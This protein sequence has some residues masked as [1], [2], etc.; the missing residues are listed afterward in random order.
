MADRLLAVLAAIDEVNRRDPS[1]VPDETP[2]ALLYGQ[3]MS[4]ALKDF[5][6]N[7]SVA[8]QIAARAQHIE[9][10]II[11]RDSYP[12][13]R[14]A[15]LSWRKDLQKHHAKRAGDLMAAAGYEAAA[16]ERVAS[17]LKKERLKHDDEVQTLEDVICLV[18]LAHEAPE[19]IAR[20]DDAKV[21]D[22][23]AKTAKKMSPAGLAAAGRLNL[24]G[25]LARLLGKALAS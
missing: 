22:I 5:A 3:R 21:T 20:H 7:A 6:P 25:R 24:D 23:L 16:I 10:W 1:R 8:L 19:F 15:Y 18:F 12:E 4:A 2:R 17:L 14:V 13:G 9:R 11:P